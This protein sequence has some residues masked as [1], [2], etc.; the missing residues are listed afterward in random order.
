MRKQETAVLKSNQMA[1]FTLR[2]EKTAE[3]RK[4][5]TLKYQTEF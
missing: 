4:K 3:I 1:V 5:M 2:E